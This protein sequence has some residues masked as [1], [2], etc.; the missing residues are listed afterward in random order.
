[1][2][3]GSERARHRTWRLRAMSSSSTFCFAEIDV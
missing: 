1:M 2:D 3:T